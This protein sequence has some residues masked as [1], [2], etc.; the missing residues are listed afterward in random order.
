MKIPFSKM[1]G[2]GNDFVVIDCRSESYGIEEHHVRAIAD[3]RLGVGCDQI[4]FLVNPENSEANTGYKIVNR[5]GS[6]AEQCGNGLRCVVE[7]LRRKDQVKT[8]ALVEVG[9]ELIEAYICEN[10]HITVKIA[11]P[12]FSSQSVSLTVPKRGNYY[13]HELFGEKFHFGMV[14]MGNP[15][16][17]TKI[18]LTEEAQIEKIGASVQSSGAF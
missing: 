4:L 16:A 14:S 12:D 3:R 8:G 10:G 6:P 11:P 17:V 2:L 13:V 1:H 7:Y 5:D 18:S 9:E 15:H